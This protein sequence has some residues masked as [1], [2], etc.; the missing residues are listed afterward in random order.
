MGG[1]VN[2]T[3]MRHLLGNLDFEDGVEA[4]RKGE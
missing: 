4:H 2:M 1:V 3:G